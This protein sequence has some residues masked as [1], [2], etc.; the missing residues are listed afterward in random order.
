M[1]A[2]NTFSD[3]SLPG[4]DLNPQPLDEIQIHPKRFPEDNEFNYTFE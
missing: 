4:R 3:F 2:F 1:Q